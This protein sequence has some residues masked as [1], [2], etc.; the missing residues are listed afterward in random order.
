MSRVGPTPRQ[1]SEE[2]QDNITSGV[3]VACSGRFVVKGGV[4]L[5]HETVPADERES[6]VE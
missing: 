4:I 1:G 6:T 5:E 2:T 3:C